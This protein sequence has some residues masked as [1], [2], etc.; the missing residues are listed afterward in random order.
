MYTTTTLFRRERM[1]SRSL[2][3]IPTSIE[4]EFIEKGAISK[5]D[6][7]KKQHRNKRI[8]LH[9]R[10]PKNLTD[11]IDEF[12]LDTFGVSRTSFILQAIHEKLKRTKQE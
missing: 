6:I 9:L 7:S 1:V 12:L 10:I 4:N 8:S 5:I 11:Q 2:K 3:E